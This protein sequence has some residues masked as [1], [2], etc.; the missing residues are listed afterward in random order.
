MRWVILI[1]FF[2]YSGRASAK[3]GL[4][5]YQKQLNKMWVAR[6]SLDKAL[7]SRDTMVLK[8]LLHDHV[9]YGHSNG[10]VESKRDVIEDLYNGKLVYKSIQDLGYYGTGEK[11]EKGLLR[12]DRKPTSK[13]SLYK[14][15][16]LGGFARKI[17]TITSIYDVDV[18]VEGKQ[19]KLRLSVMQVWQKKGKSWK[20]IA[21]Q[22]VKV[23]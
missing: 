5:S 10:W 6:E 18:V 22:S 19:I 1:L 14:N 12:I 16:F 9:L 21:R 17:I 13:D 11:E 15:S 23:S 7:I 2:V 20:L 3:F 4:G 8:R